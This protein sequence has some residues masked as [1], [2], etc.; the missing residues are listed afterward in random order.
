[1][2]KT[3]K[4]AIRGDAFLILPKKPIDSKRVYEKIMDFMTKHGASNVR[5]MDHG[6][7]KIMLVA[8]KAAA[9]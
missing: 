3:P 5:Q 6:P 1:M 4:N 8:I 9:Q 7:H 2:T